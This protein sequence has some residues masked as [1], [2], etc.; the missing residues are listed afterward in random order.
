MIW[1][2]PVGLFLLLRHAIR[3]RCDTWRTAVVY[4]G[5]LLSVVVTLFSS[6]VLTFAAGYRG[7]TLDRKLELDRKAVSAEE[8]YDTAV[9]LI[10]SINRETAEVGFL[11]DGF[12][13]MPYTLAEM[14]DKLLDA[15]DA[16]ADK[17]D[18]IT[19]ADSRVKPVLSEWWE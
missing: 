8:L 4:I 12:S 11:E 9:I 5:I 17:H 1:L 3:R 19:H 16:F 14:N 15:Y 7:E 13:V 6:F 18:F 2:L 10:D